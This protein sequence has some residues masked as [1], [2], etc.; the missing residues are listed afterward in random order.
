MLKIKKV[1][2]L[3]GKMSILGVTKLSKNVQDAMNEA[4]DSFF[5][6]KTLQ[7]KLEKQISSKF[8]TKN[9]FVTASASAGITISMMAIRNHL[10]PND[11]NKKIKVLLPMGHHIDYG[12]PIQNLIEFGKAEIIPIG[13]ANKLTM[14]DLKESMSLTFDVAFYVSSHHCVQKNHISA[15]TYIDFYKKQNKMTVIDIAAEENIWKFSDYK[16]TMCVISGSKAI[17]GP[18][19]GV[20]LIDDFDKDKFLQLQK[21]EGR[22]MKVS[23]ENMLGLSAAISDYSKK[24]VISSVEKMIDSYI[25]KIKEKIKFE[26]T[27]KID[28]KRL[29]ERIKISGNVAEIK[30]FN[31]WL[32]SKHIYVRDHYQ[33]QGFVELDLRQI[34]EAEMELFISTLEKVKND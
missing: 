2:N 31:N 7:E 11:A 16:P 21:K 15:K 29:I 22:A 20:V 33:N 12:A 24:R 34:S 8:K 10:Y 3:S 4:S 30:K 19:T 28:S 13:S 23:K 1:V 26:V 9:C 25:L 32:K 27:K 18:T 5:L 17:S 14:N 6:I